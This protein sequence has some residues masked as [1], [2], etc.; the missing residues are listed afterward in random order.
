MKSKP[1]TLSIITIVL[2]NKVFFERTIQSVINQDYK[3]YEYI[4]ID[5][6]STDGTL[7]VMQKYRSNIHISISERDSGIYNAINKGINLATGKWVLI[8]NAGDRLFSRDTLSKV[9]DRKLSEEKDVLYGDWFS[10][11][12]LASP[13]K[14]M[15][16]KADYKKGNLLH[17]SIIYKKKLH[18]EKGPY[19]ETK[20]L[21]VSDYIF[22]ANLPENTF[23]YLNMPISIN[24][25]TGVSSKFWSYKQKLAYDYILGRVSLLFFFGECIRIYIP[26]IDLFV[27][28]RIKRFLK[29]FS[30]K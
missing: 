10:C 14:L 17:Q 12:L 7:D 26:R 15:E 2:N 28:Q 22:F 27:F 11:N 6:G 5:G 9:F 16:G 18:D 25:N 13:E 1:P 19:I 21:I 30:Q 3:N 4:V 20:K 24:D 29:I 8:L 23:E